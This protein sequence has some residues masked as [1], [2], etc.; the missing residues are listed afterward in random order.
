[1]ADPLHTTRIED[2]PP[3]RS[4]WD[5]S[6][7]SSDTATSWKPPKYSSVFIGRKPLR[8]YRIAVES[9]IKRDGGVWI[10]A[11][12]DLISRAVLVAIQITKRANLMLQTTLGSKM[13]EGKDKKPREVPNI[14]ILITYPSPSMVSY[15]F[16]IPPTPE[17]PTSPTV[18]P[19]QPPYTTGDFPEQKPETTN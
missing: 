16:T 7:T 15:K 5:D 4:P 3:F 6:G 11:R 12:G 9:T 10:E 18:D 1:M 2:H 13:M 19:R 17:P 14:A 8:V